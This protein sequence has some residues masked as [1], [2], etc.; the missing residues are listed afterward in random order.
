MVYAMGASVGKYTLMGTS[1]DEWE[2]E[3]DDGTTKNISKDELILM[4]NEQAKDVK[5]TATEGTRDRV[6]IE[7]DIGIRANDIRLQKRSN[8]R[9]ARALTRATNTGHKTANEYL[10]P[11]ER[12]ENGPPGAC[13]N[14][15]GP[16]SGQ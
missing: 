1:G 7:R 4:L 3:H 12:A 11:I 15:T 2:L 5:W 6:A 14:W 16:S 8:L 10:G 13:A 9:T